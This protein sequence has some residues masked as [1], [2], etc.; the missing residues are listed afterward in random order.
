MMDERAG[1]DGGKSG[2]GGCVVSCGLRLY[3]FINDGLGDGGHD[4]VVCVSSD[5]GYDG[6]DTADVFYVGSRCNGCD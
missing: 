2:L 6:G 5:D 1:S 3:Y 4:V